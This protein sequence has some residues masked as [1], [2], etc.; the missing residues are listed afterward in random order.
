[1]CVGL[2]VF[3]FPILP[4]ACTADQF[5]GA[6]GGDAGNDVR[7][8]QA[9]NDAGNPVDAPT[10]LDSG[11]S[12][13]IALSDG[14]VSDAANPDTFMCG[15]S[16]SCS[17]ALQFC[18]DVTGTCKAL[19]TACLCNHTCNCVTTH[20]SNFCEGGATPTCNTSGGGSEITVGCP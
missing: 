15:N 16:S 5:V 12:D 11:K 13:A 6:D 19:P 9:N 10:T 7:S 2:V 8:D 4:L 14:C 18:D 3:A 17:A 20:L 1:M